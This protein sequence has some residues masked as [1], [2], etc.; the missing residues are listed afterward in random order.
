MPEFRALARL[1]DTVLPDDAGLTF[2]FKEGWREHSRLCDRRL[3]TEGGRQRKSGGMKVDNNRLE[4]QS[5]G[6]RMPNPTAA[7]VLAT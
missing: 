3:D 1:P 6:D 4:P 5:K 2:A 7:L